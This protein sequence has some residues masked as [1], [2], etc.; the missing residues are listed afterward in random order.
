MT[1]DGYLKIINGIKF[2]EIKSWIDFETSFVREDAIK[3]LHMR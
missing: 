2:N 1:Y 3:S